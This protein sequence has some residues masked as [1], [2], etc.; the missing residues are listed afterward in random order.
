MLVDAVISPLPYALALLIGMLICLELGRRVGLRDLKRNAHGAGVGLETVQGAV[1]GLFGLLVAFT[2]SGA[3]A[4]LDVRRQLVA[5]E[6]NDI[7][8]AWLRLDL[9]PPEVQPM[10]R[11][12][13][14]DYT[15]A[16]LSAYAKLPDMKAARAELARSVVLQQSIWKA[17]VAATRL[18]GAHPDAAKLLLP[19][20]NAMIDITTTRTTAMR[21]HPPPMIFLLLMVIA[22]ASSV[23]AGY[24]MAGSPGRKWIHMLTFAGTSVIA[25]FIVLQIEYPRSG[26]IRVSELEDTLVELRQSMN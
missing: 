7:G 18:P 23:L 26:L 25:M 9:L 21:I 13:F 20:L 10:M 14:R 19:A 4:R 17:S 16:R 24:S 1:F 15:D 6:A 22:L 3:P 11:Q 12:Q 8:T 5:E 2:F